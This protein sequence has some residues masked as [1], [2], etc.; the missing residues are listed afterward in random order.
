VKVLSCLKGNFSFRGF[1]GEESS[2]GGGDLAFDETS[3]G[4]STFFGRERLV[5]EPFENVIS[6]VAGDVLCSFH[7]GE[8]VGDVTL[9][10]FF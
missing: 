1:F 4:A 10:D 6:G 9:Q 3:D 8:N 5:H 2:D 7:A